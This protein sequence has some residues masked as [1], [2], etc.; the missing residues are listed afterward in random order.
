[1]IF[2]CRKTI[3]KA[4]ETWSAVSGVR[5]IYTRQTPDIE[6]RFEKGNHGDG[7]SVAFDGE[8]K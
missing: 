1:M 7:R 3:R 5:F 6:V 4:F 8:S 2:A